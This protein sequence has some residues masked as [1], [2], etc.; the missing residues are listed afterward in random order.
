METPFE[1]IA[2]IFAIIMEPANRLEDDLYRFAFMHVCRYWRNVASRKPTLW[3]S[4]DLRESAHWI[5]Q[6]LLLSQQC[7]LRVTAIEVPCANG[8]ILQTILFDHMYRIEHLRA[9]SVPNFILGDTRALR[10]LELSI[11]TDSVKTFQRQ[12]QGGEA[13]ALERLAIHAPKLD[14]NIWRQICNRRLQFLCIS[15]NSNA[16]FGNALPMIEALNGIPLLKTLKLK[17][18]FPSNMSPLSRSE[19]I[20]TFAHLHAISITATGQCCSDFFSYLRL[21]VLKKIEIVVTGDRDFI[22]DRHIPHIDCLHDGERFQLED[23][24]IHAWGM[25][26]DLWKSMR[27]SRLK[28]LK[29]G[30]HTNEN[31]SGHL[32]IPALKYL[33]CLERLDVGFTPRFSSP[34]PSADCVVTLNCLQIVRLTGPTEMSVIFLTYLRLPALREIV[35]EVHCSY[36]EEHPPIPPLGLQLPQFSF[37]S[38]RI[39]GIEGNNSDIVLSTRP[40]DRDGLSAGSANALRFTLSLES[41]NIPEACKVLRAGLLISEVTML[42]LDICGLRDDRVFISILSAPKLRQL[43]LQGFGGSDEVLKTLFLWNCDS[44]QLLLPRNLEILEL[45]GINFWSWSWAFVPLQRNIRD[46]LHQGHERPVKLASLMYTQCTMGSNQTIINRLHY[47][48]GVDT[49]D[50]VYRQCSAGEPSIWNTDSLGVSED[51]DF[52]YG[53]KLDRAP[54]PLDDAWGNMY[55]TVEETSG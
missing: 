46:S 12:F 51:E 19:E 44:D 41:C 54:S 29:I 36:P 31:R 3:S 16:T 38:L 35:L 18:C 4:L 7:P 15:C 27:H 25:E 47:I 30:C 13:P 40:L 45:V 53:E 20:I 43:R 1:I 42:E 8:E 33:P 32:L 49:G 39:E 10:S 21:P 34:F 9:D 22:Q 11:D 48:C 24:T 55:G 37:A 14:C 5:K 23:V 50:I 17:G 6:Y 52:E 28:T 26:D 2:E